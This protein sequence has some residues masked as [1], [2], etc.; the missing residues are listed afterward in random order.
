MRLRIND[1]ATLSNSLQDELRLLRLIP[2][3]TMLKSFPRTIRQISQELNKT[4]NLKIIGE[5]VKMD[6]LILEGLQDP[7]LHL[8]R[9]AIDHGIE[10]A[11]QR[12]DKGKPAAGQ[13]TITITD[14]GN[15]ILLTIADDGGG[16]DYQKIASIAQH[17]NIVTASQLALLSP[18]E[19]LALIF[20]PGFSTKEIITTISGR[21]VGLDVVKANVNDLKGQVSVQT[22]LGQGTIFTLCVPLTLSSERGLM[23]RSGGQPFVIPTQAVQRVLALTRADII[24][25]EA[26]D[27]IM[28]DGHPIPLLS[29]ATILGLNNAEPAH[30]N[31]LSIVVIKKGWHTLALLVDDI[32]GE[33]EIVLKTLQPPL[34]NI[35]GIAGGTLSSNGQVILILNIADLI[36]QALDKTNQIRLTPPEITLQKS[37]PP[38]ILV[39]DDSIT[40]RTLEKNILENKGYKVTTA[41]NG[42]EAWDLLQQNHYSLLI[43][44]VNMPIMDGFAL[45]TKV[46]QSE[47][48]NTLPVIIVTSLNSDA[49]KRQGVTA[50]ANAYIV[51][52]EFESD[53]LLELVSQLVH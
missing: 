32:I 30:Q 11:E 16:I 19:I 5:D 38:H 47:K 33:R 43:S 21:G 45:T 46:K 40:T 17:K 22:T 7:L 20:Y 50:G 36:N 37:G 44:D 14:A 1:L 3:A 41:V 23:I 4:V 8:L 9:N 25:V 18:D 39:V 53:T 35:P 6:K 2:A 42:K 27:A 48:L 34:A 31:K 10:S 13:I 29:L 12:L 49:E 24:E 51:K 15:Q 28:V 52:N 26:C